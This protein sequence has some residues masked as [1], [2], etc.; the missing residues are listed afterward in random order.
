MGDR[1]FYRCFIESLNFLENGQQLY[2]LFDLIQFRSRISSQIN[3]S[4][5]GENVQQFNTSWFVHTGTTHPIIKALKFISYSF[6]RLTD[7]R[8][9]LFKY[10]N[11]IHWHFIFK[12]NVI[13][14]GIGWLCGLDVS[15]TR[16]RSLYENFSI[17]WNEMSLVSVISHHLW[18]LTLFCMWIYFVPLIHTYV[19]SIDV[20]QFEDKAHF[21]QSRVCSQC[22]Q[23]HILNKMITRMLKRIEVVYQDDGYG[24]NIMWSSRASFMCT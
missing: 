4:N 21:K 7:Q 3:P 16:T 10:W 17:L 24:T 19:R 12:E 22:L 20:I 11:S 2:P 14:M 15:A 18:Q 6:Q 1:F 5:F 13:H 23:P 9:A 8:P